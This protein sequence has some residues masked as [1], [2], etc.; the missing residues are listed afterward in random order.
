MK[1]NLTTLLKKIY[2]DQVLKNTEPKYP[3]VNCSWS[4][5]S[6]FF[7][8]ILLLSKMN[9]RLF[10]KHA[11]FEAVIATRIHASNIYFHHCTIFHMKNI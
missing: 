9:M 4:I 10:E 3:W 1:Q 6:L 8:I 2:F 7:Y 5:S 11:C